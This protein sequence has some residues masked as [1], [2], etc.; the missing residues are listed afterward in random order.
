MD[1]PCRENSQVRTTLKMLCGFALLWLAVACDGRLGDDNEADQAL[2]S[3]GEAVS[4]EAVAAE[5]CRPGTYKIA[6]QG[7]LTGDF[8]A[9]GEDMING[10]R[11][12]VDE[13]N[14]LEVAG[15][16]VRLEVEPFDSQGSG[17]Q[18]PPLANQAADD[19]EVIAMV[20]PTL[21]HETKVAGPFFEEAELPFI[22][23]SATAPPQN[24]EA[25]KF[26]FRMVGSERAQAHA[27]AVF[28][29]DH[30]GAS[31]VAVID[32]SS[33]QYGKP[34]ADNAAQALGRYGIDVVHRAS[35]LPGSDDYSTQVS[36]V[37]SSGAEAVFFGGY[38][39]EAGV[40]KRKL[41][42]MGGG[43]I[44]FVSDD[45]A[46]ASQYLDA[47]EPENPDPTYVIFPGL[48]P[49]TAGP[50]FTQAYREQ[51]GA[52]PGA[53]SLEAYDAASLI[54]EGLRWGACERT[55]MRDFL[56]S[57]DGEIRGRNISF[58]NGGDIEDPQFTVYRALNDGW[59]VEVQH[60][61]PPPVGTSPG[62]TTSPK[63]SP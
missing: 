49:G 23:P 63:R 5:G 42:A 3:S 50:E 22:T 48:D 31:A 38:Y 6:Y 51:H 36:D 13:A 40:I 20:G 54:I 17:D 4:T 62:S 35:V 18:A 28:I 25:W 2:E 44:P 33:P 27:A 32:D 34:M 47:V 9:L 12:A 45:G 11:F 24:E 55:A 46:Y 43:S 8:A 41:A 14:Q 60:L 15:D 58:D 26:F 52:G 53:F 61:T 10:I 56:A 30:L 21:W 59:A 1:P 39:R 16:R 7:P 19:E 29:A 57:Y 37:L